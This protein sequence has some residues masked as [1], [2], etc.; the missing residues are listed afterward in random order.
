MI[1]GTTRTVAP[2]IREHPRPAWRGFRTWQRSLIL[3]GALY[4]GFRPPWDTSRAR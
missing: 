1:P 2:A 3:G 4:A